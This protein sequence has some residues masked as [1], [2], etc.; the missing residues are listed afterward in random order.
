[1]DHAPPS[2]GLTAIIK[3][4]TMKLLLN[5]LL[6]AMALMAVAQL[7]S[8]IHVA[9]LGTALVAAFVIGLLNLLLRPILVILTL[10]VTVLTLGLFL[11]VINAGMFW[12]AARVL[13]GFSVDGFGGAL[14]GSLVYSLLRMAIES[15]LDQ[16]LSRH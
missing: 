12:V 8:G 5:W 10:P 13:D 2:C 7:I 11:F 3:G 1:M 15:A 4:K 14:L 16:L 6:S 9:G